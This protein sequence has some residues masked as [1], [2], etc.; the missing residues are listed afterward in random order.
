MLMRVSSH[1]TG[2]DAVGLNTISLNA[3][4]DFYVKKKSLSSVYLVF[5]GV[6][7]IVKDRLLDILEFDLVS[8]NI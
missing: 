6:F 8:N 2:W 4:G 5:A 1:R 3:K 7:E